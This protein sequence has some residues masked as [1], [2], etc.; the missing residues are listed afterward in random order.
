MVLYKLSYAFFPVKDVYSRNKVDI[1]DWLHQFG[2]KEL[3]GLEVHPEFGKGK[4]GGVEDIIEVEKGELRYDFGG[5][6]AKC[7]ALVEIPLGTDFVVKIPLESL[8]SFPFFQRNF[9]ERKTAGLYGVHTCNE[10]SITSSYVPQDIYEALRDLDISPYLHKAE[11]HIKEVNRAL[12]HH[13]SKHY[14]AF[15]KPTKPDDFN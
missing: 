8:P 11:Q 1:V 3:Q 2:D 13:R 5:R 15:P 10:I 12:N 9:T 4:L 7:A 6:I 14:I